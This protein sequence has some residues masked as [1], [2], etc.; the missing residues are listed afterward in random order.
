MSRVVRSRVWTAS[1]G[2]AWIFALATGCV[3]DPVGDPCVPEQVPVGGF[4]SSETY[5]ETSSPQCLSRLC[6]VR[7]L[8]GDPTETCTESCATEAQARDHVYCTCRCD[9]SAGSEPCAC[10]DGF[11]CESSGMLGSFCVRDAP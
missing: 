3:G 5:L 1:F 9:D 7:G 2:L 6:L 10:P 11:L 4:A 8:S